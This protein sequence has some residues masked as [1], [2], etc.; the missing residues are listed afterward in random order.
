MVE[1]RWPAEY[2]VRPPRPDEAE[3]VAALICACDIADTG[4]PDWN[5]EETR[6]DWIR[7]GFDLA[8]D[9]RVVEAPDGRL[10]AYTDVF[11]RPNA[12]EVAANTCL[13]PEFRSPELDEAL[14]VLGESLAAQHAPLPVRQMVPAWRGQ[15]F[16]ARGYNPQRWLWR[17]RGDL[18][19]PPPEPEWPDGFG[20]RTM[21]PADERRVYE[22][23]EE[24]FV[25][26]ERAP[27]AY[28]EWRRFI[29]EREDFDRSLAFIAVNG[30]AIV[31]TA[32]CLMDAGGDEGWVRQLA[33]DERYRGRGLGKALLLHAFGVF[34]RRG[35]TRSGLGVDANNPSA[36]KLYL[37]VG[38]WSLQEYVQ[39][40]R[41][42]PG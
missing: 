2:R 33:V 40:Q 16:E 30:S 3:K 7:L 37:G 32:M 5:V 13:N 34:H 27:V 21:K 11:V 36:T 24:A 19:Q 12:V 39:Y 1:P 6:G 22:L 17:M 41:F 38:M 10:V 23:I 35:A 18:T 9:A 31:G 26:P 8:R 42:S 15:V 4:E 25:R 14:I 29:V 20:V 28:E